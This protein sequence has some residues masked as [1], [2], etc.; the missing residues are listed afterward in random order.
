MG[1]SGQCDEDQRLKEARIWDRTVTIKE[2]KPQI[3]EIKALPHGYATT[4]KKSS[5][6]YLDCS[7]FHRLLLV[8]TEA[9]GF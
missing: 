1:R 4:Q 7:E 6:D 3:S 9:R 2:I 5:K 8:A